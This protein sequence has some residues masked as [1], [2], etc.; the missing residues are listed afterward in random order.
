MTMRVVNFGIA[1]LIA[2]TLSLAAAQAASPVSSGQPERLASQ[3]A[4][5]PDISAQSRRRTRRTPRITV[6][7][8]MSPAPGQDYRRLCRPVFEER[9]IPQWGGRVLYASQNCRWVPVPPGTPP[10]W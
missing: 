4:A 8:R 5:G 10:A 1:A 3:R 2:G 9:W 7:P 6:R